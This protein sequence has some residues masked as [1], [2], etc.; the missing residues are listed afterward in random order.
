MN[1]RSRM[2]SPPKWE[3]REVFQYLSK[4]FLK[5]TQTLIDQGAFRQEQDAVVAKCKEVT[6]TAGLKEG[7]HGVVKLCRKVGA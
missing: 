7:S 2:R 4:P 1:I 3:M 6:G 5:D